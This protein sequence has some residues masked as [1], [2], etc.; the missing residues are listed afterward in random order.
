MYELRI[1]PLINENYSCM[2]SSVSGHW[3]PERARWSH[4]ERSTY[5]LCPTRKMYHVWFF[6]PCN[7]SFSDQACSV[8]TAGYWPCSLFACLRTSTSSRSLN[9]QKMKLANFQPSWPHAW[10]IA[11]ISDAKGRMWYSLW[12][13]VAIMLRTGRWILI[14]KFFFFSDLYRKK[15]NWSLPRVFFALLT[16]M[17]TILPMKMKNETTFAWKLTWADKVTTL[18]TKHYRTANSDLTA[19]VLLDQRLVEKMIA[20]QG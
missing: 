9:T 3:L 15:M 19:S 7:K 10:S 14:S 8:K 20:G 2:T 18:D 6:I 4:L 16:K 13:G 12:M 17:P 5:G 11:C 1:I